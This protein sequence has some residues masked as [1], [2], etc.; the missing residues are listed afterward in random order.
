M[1]FRIV[2]MD[3]LIKEKDTDP[4][5]KVYIEVSRISEESGEDQTLMFDILATANQLK[6]GHRDYIESCIT[7]MLGEWGPQ[8]IVGDTWSNDLDIIVE[9]DY[10]VM[11]A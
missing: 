8:H 1:I 2:A 11:A 10:T 6:D 5:Y 7:E 4:E 3:T 9:P